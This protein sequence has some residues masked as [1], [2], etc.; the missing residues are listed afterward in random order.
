MAIVGV[1]AA[2]TVAAMTPA[3]GVMPPR[4]VTAV[5]D[6][7]RVAIGSIGGRPASTGI[8]RQRIVTPIQPTLL[9][10]AAQLLDAGAPAAT[11]GILL[12]VIL[13]LLTLGQQQGTAPGLA[14]LERLG[15]TQH[16]KQCT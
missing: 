4:P 1:V 9:G 12:F 10:P 7:G 14:G 8:I 15:R 2:I 3:A 5:V 11:A 13:V 6:A 16:C